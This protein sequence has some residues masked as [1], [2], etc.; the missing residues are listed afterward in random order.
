MPQFAI[1]G[2]MPTTHPKLDSKYA[3]NADGSLNLVVY[4]TTAD[5]VNLPFVKYVVLWQCNIELA[6]DLTQ[7]CVFVVE[8]GQTKSIEIRIPAGIMPIGIC[9]VNVELKT[10][11]GKVSYAKYT[12]EVP[13][14]P[15]HTH[16]PFDPT[17]STDVIYVS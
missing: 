17:E 8:S 14:S 7:A 15:F 11:D 3:A 13:H 4:T 2:L 16:A 9:T 12:V 5:D 1:P 10:N 6:S